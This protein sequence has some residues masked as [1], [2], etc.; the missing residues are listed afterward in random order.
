M[1]RVSVE[2]G[3]FL[4]QARE[5]IGLSLD[6]LQEKTRIQ[7]SFLVAIENG[8]FNK[9]PSPFYVRTYLRSYANCVKVEPHHILRQYRKE[10]QRER[11][12][13]GVHQAITE[14]MLTN[15]L[16]T[17]Q[18]PHVT[19]QTRSMPTIGSQFQSGAN[20][21]KHRTS[22]N[23]ALTIA[24][25]QELINRSSD[26]ARRD[27]GYQRTSGGTRSIPGLT[28]SETESIPTLN[29]TLVSK[30]TNPIKRYAD[31]STANQKMR[32]SETTSLSR[33]RNLKDSNP[34]MRTTDP[35]VGRVW[36]KSQPTGTERFQTSTTSMDEVLSRSSRSSRSS[37]LKK[38]TAPS[39]TSAR[40]SGSHKK[41]E[42]QP[43]SEVSLHNQL[44]RSSVNKLKNKK[45]SQ[46]FPVTMVS[47][48]AAGLLVCGGLVWG[49][50]Q[51]FGNDEAPSS[52]SADKKKGSTN[53]GKVSPDV[54][55]QTKIDPVN[56]TSKQNTYK[57]SGVKGEV[58]LTFVGSGGES[59]IVIAN[60]GEG[61]EAN[62]LE[63][64]TVTNGFTWNYKY[65]FDKNQNL[66]IKMSQPKNIALS[67]N[68]KVINSAELVNVQY[69]E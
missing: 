21:T 57:L 22:V 17:L 33:K 67:V 4:R 39:S 59:R 15:S 45:T 34:S 14:D 3:S 9:L 46:K 6:Q 60:T 16:Q 65:D 27:L 32:S 54:M 44:S 35:S 20:Q 25:T 51:F 68:G 37:R 64:V 55:A 26:P 53:I 29:Q 42:T 11:G 40:V 38:E 30:N 62:S 50:T 7:K 13:T 58:K 18:A 69:A 1:A 23:T 5:S 52:S 12:L 36:E 43:D 49:A 63:D 19:G 61:I 31:E 2:I 47:S 66:W 48:I 8:D 41:I 24:K 56:E 10:E 28:R